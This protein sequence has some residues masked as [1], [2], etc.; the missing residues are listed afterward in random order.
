VLLVPDGYATRDPSFKGDPYGI[1][2]LGPT[3]LAAIKS[4]VQGGGRYVGWLDGAVLAAA[5][6]VSSAT[7]DDAEDLGISSPGAL[8]RTVADTASPLDADVGP[9][10][11]AFWDSRYVMRANGAPVPLR[12]PDA[13]TEDFFVSGYAD[14]PEPLGG[15]AAIVDESVGSGRTVAFGFEPNFRAFTDGTAQILRNAILGAD[16]QPLARIASVRAHSAR[17]AT[18]RRAALRM[19]S[20]HAPARLVVARRGTKAARRILRR[21]HL[22]VRTERARGRTTFLIGT[23]GRSGDELPWARTVERRL[24]RAAVPVVMY[25]VP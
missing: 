4:W 21:S 20:A 23:R 12:F 1:K 2:S 10:A 7:F 18:A 13:G 15:S 6:G 11:W 9:Y 19:R 25:R 14:K 22:K 3:G 24:R 8:I 16:P 5:A 17:R